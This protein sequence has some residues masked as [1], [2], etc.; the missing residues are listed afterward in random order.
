MQHYYKHSGKFRY[1]TKEVVNPATGDVVLEAKE[2]PFAMNQLKNML[3]QRHFICLN[4]SRGGG[5]LIPKSTIA[6]MLKSQSSRALRVLLR[7]ESF[8]LRVPV[9]RMLFESFLI[10]AQVDKK[11]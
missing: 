1:Y 2:R 9:V 3:E 11:G 10:I 8:I 7:T 5:W 4:A 6:K